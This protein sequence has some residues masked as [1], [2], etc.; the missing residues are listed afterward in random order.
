MATKRK[1]KVNQRTFDH[2]KLL[3]KAGER[4]D[5]VAEYLEISKWT[6]GVIAHSETFEEYKN[7]LAAIYAKQRN[8]R[9]EKKTEEISTPEE[10]QEKKDEK[11]IGDYKL[12]G[13]T[14]SANY[15][16]N[17]L[18]ELVKKQNELLELIS[19]KMAFIVDELS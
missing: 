2:A 3:L 12:P 11:I 13:G 15:Q 17:R 16:F 1:V 6:V 10:K 4:Y 7:T 9:E 14:M 19:N 18:V 5:G 8:K